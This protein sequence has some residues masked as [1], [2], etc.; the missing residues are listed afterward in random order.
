MDAH[1]AL[2]WFSTS[3]ENTTTNI[4]TCVG[5]MDDRVNGFNDG[6]DDVG[7]FNDGIDGINEVESVDNVHGVEDHRRRCC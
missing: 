6:I 7:S 4:G 1:I 2:Y 5:G 3:L